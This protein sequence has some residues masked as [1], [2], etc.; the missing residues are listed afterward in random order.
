MSQAI[1]ECKDLKKEY[2]L[3][4]TK[5]EALKGVSFTITEGEFSAIAGPSGSGKSTILNMIGCIDHP[6]SGDVIIKGTNVGGLNDK[7]L[8]RYRRHTVSFIFQSFNLIPVLNVY[9]NIELPLL[10][11][12]RFTQEERH[13]KVM[14]F[15]EEVGLADRLK[16]KP[17]E[18]S[19]GQRQRVAI[20][21][22]LVTGPLVVLAD[23]P[24]ANLDSDTGIK[25]IE[26]MKSINKND[27]TTFIFSTHDAHI[28]DQARRVI[29][30]RDGL[31]IGDEVKQEGRQVAGSREV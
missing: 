2:L 14:R 9:E 5:V 15:V 16:N 31:I 1:I 8:T 27:G 3:G 13:Q 19:G 11:E 24:T 7:E 12:K 29:K 10:L 26:L 20:A 17:G 28:M 23:E 21:R 22:A 25:I 30:I 6:S 4:S 18:L